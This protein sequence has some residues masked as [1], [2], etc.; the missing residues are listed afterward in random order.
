MIELG[1]N[2]AR[3][4]TLVI[5]TQLL[6]TTV[7]YLVTVRNVVACDDEEAMWED[8]IILVKKA[9]IPIGVVAFLW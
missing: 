5:I 8:I 7:D 9:I 3:I 1:I 6:N 2:G 4:D